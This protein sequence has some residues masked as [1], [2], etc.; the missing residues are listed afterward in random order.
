MGTHCCHHVEPPAGDADRNYRRVL[1]AALAINAAMFGTEL[2]AGL[3]AGSVALQADA[4]D[5]LGDAANYAISLFVLGM[6]LRWRA[7]A[8]MA[9]GLSMGAFG[10]WVIAATAH[11]LTSGGVPE[12]G[13]MGIVGVLAFAANVGV[14]V[15]LFRFR[16]GDSNRRSV[17]LCS[18]NDAIGNLA[19]VIAASGVFATGSAWPDLLVASVMATLALTAAVQVLR[20]AAGEL[21]VR[22]AEAD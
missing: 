11:G 19:V 21:R 2:A 1:W 22:P 7:A 20:Q 6:S 15:M 3:A 12:A 9:K 5:F 16:G 17:W 10:I 18:R 14:A 8:G 4:L 13:I